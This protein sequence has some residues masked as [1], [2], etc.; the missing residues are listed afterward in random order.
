MYVTFLNVTVMTMLVLLLLF[1]LIDSFYNKTAEIIFILKLVELL[2]LKSL[3]WV[4][5]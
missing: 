5:F 2:S 4:M 3:K 1:F